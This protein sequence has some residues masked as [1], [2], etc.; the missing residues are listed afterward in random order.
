MSRSGYSC[1]CENI[2][3]WR[4]AVERAVKGRR[5]QKALALI[6][7]ALDAM[8]DKQLAANSFQSDC[9]P[10][11]FGALAQLL[12]ID[13]SDLEAKPGL[14]EDYVDRD[15]VGRRFDVAPSMAAEIMFLND[16]GCVYSESPAQRWQRM[17]RV[18]D[19]MME[20]RWHA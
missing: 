17:R 20:G 11:T 1:D 10:C 12:G 18:I 3:L 5:G 4:Q 13:T 15:E 14:D 7:K 9:G 2:G 16:E 8:P 6:T 19:D